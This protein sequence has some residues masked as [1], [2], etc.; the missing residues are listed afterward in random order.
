[1]WPQAGALLDPR[2][3]ELLTQKIR[4]VGYVATG[5]DFVLRVGEAP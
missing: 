3:G 2:E 5:D 1:V 4:V